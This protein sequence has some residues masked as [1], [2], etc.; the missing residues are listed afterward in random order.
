MAAIATSKKPAMAT[1][2]AT[3]TTAII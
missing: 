2:V 3:R 1:P